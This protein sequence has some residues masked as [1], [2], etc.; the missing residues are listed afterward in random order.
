MVVL[1]ALVVEEEEEEERCEGEVLKVAR[2][3]R[4]FCKFGERHR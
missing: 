2:L 1:E 4:G 3:N